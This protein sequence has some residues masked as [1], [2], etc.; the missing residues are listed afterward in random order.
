MR[1]HILL[2]HPADGRAR[3]LGLV[4]SLFAAREN[5][6]RRVVERAHALERSKGGG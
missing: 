1:L 2:V 4:D 3:P 6:E 5:P